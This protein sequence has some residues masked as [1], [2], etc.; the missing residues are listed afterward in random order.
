MPSPV[1]KMF[2]TL[3]SKITREFITLSFEK[4]ER[5]KG[6]SPSPL[7][8]EFRTLNSKTVRELKALNF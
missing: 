5:K 6:G 4:V 7:A 8:R 1:V 2:I 3:N